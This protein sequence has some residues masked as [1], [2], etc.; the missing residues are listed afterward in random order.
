MVRAE[1]GPDAANP[2][3]TG[4]GGAAPA[5]TGYVVDDLN[6]DV[7]RATVS[8]GDRE[9]SVPGL[10]FDLLVA[11]A[12]HSPNIASADT[13]M[14]EVWPRVIVS[15]ETLTQ[16]VKLLREALGDDPQNPKYVASVRGRGYRLV[17]PVAVPSASHAVAAAATVATSA[18]VATAA[19]VDAP[20]PRDRWRLPLLMFG[21][22]L[23]TATV[24]GVVQ[25]RNTAEPAVSAS[26]S[27]AATPNVP[28][29]PLPRG[30]AVLP[31][32]DLGGGRSSDVLSLGIPEAVLHQ[33]AAQDRFPVISR[34]S[35][36]A[37]EK[38]AT[39]A[40]EIGRRLNV[41][42][43]VEGSVQRDRERLRVTAQLID[44]ESGD[45]VWSMQFDEEPR[46]VFE[47]QDEIATEVAR[48]LKISLSG[49]GNA[50][51][52]RAA[53]AKFEAYLE[54]LQGS[55]LL[56]TWR[57]SDA[58]A[59][60]R[61][62][63]RALAIDPEYAAAHVLLASAR[64]R[65]AEFDP[66]ESRA[67]V[68][69][70]AL[71]GVR[72]S[73]DRALELDPVEPRA[74]SARG[75]LNAFVDPV[76]S[77]SDYRRSLE[78]NPNDS[79]AY[80]GLAAVLFADR[81][82]RGEA[83]ALIDSARALDP[84]E[85]RLDVLKA[86]YLYYHEGDFANA[87]RL[88]V[89]AL[90]KDP[91]YQPALQRLAQLFWSV[92]RLAD[93]IRISEQVVAADAGA[94]QAWQVLQYLYLGINDVVAAT[95]AIRSVRPASVAF[96]VPA[97]LLQKRWAEAG[98]AVY[99]AAAAG[100]IP[101]VG[102]PLFIAAI[103]MHARATGDYR[104]AIS[105]L[106]ARSQTAWDI[107]GV[108]A[109]NDPSGLYC[110][111]V[112]LGDLLIASGQVNRGRALLAATLTR[113]DRDISELGV[114]EVW[115]S[116][117]RPVALALL[118]R[119]TEAIAALQRGLAIQGIVHHPQLVLAIDPAFE[120]LRSGRGFATVSSSLESRI[121]RERAAVMTLRANKSIPDRSL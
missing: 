39:D 30:I 22:A 17:P 51:V 61:H 105:L 31:F 4:T 7:G 12:R 69:R 112:G 76:A 82:R 106:D 117:M 85:P 52:P 119:D 107:S 109:V 80:E 16:R 108:P 9:L 55:H 110:N 57:M 56:D 47:L 28:A 41:R 8:R 14:R 64:L 10:T 121:A 89:A 73:L 87:E 93:G 35:S 98:E 1:A 54:Y 62:A 19:A 36:F 79:R 99:D 70:D 27:A 114:N 44:A 23:L 92:G 94:L 49:A 6:I 102:E 83:R 100:N 96:D 48:A 33:L 32:R 71:P 50:A 111:A 38:S 43:L 66:G 81:S 5:V 75:Y 53:N 11:L 91:Q 40:R 63:T 60:A 29:T 58:E 101:D 88:L 34:T 15:P 59:A 45:H 118:G 90:A 78:L 103:R 116:H 74:Y 26:A 113:M 95:A 24:V 120:R 72:A 46:A 42:Y 3:G 84:L 65:A 97:L 67:T 2:A 77:E 37:V 21:V 86:T 104:R 20:V 25:L 115:A 68:F 18:V 13:L